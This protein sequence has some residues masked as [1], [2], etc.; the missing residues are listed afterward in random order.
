MFIYRN[1]LKNLLR[2]KGRN[3]LVSL[4]LLIVM[5]AA[6][7]S[8]AV[9]SASE[10]MIAD[11]QDS[12]GV[13]THLI[14]DWEYANEN[15][16]VVETVH[17]D[18]SVSI[19]SS[20]DTPEIP[21]EQFMAFAESDYV[22]STLF[23]A[24][25]L[26]TSDDIEPIPLDESLRR[27]EGMT[28][29]EL[30]EMFSKET[31]E[32]IYEFVGGAE[33]LERIISSRRDIVGSIWGYSDVS[34]MRDFLEGQRVIADGR[35]I[36]NPGEVIIGEKLAEL[37][38]LGV[39]DVFTVTGPGLNDTAVIP[40]TVVGIF[41]DYQANLNTA[42][43]WFGVEASDII[44]S[45]D[46]L[47]HSGFSD[48]FPIMEDIKFFLNDVYAVEPFAEELRYKGLSNFHT[49][50]SDVEGYEKIVEPVGNMSS[51]ATA[52]GVIVILTGAVILVFLSVINIRERK[53]EVGVLRAIGMKKH[54]LA[55]GLIC[56]SLSLVLLC[57]ALGLTAGGVLSDPVSQMLLKASEIVHEGVSFNPATL[58]LLLLIAL[59]LGV[60]SSLIGVLYITKYEPIKI[61]SEQN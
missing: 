14:M 4:I 7:V 34:I 56:E 52:F 37:N 2:N 39:G 55:G 3:I 43:V 26:Y 5:A 11:F 28:L 51:V 29:E 13:E 18:G 20:V 53:Y 8:L 49:L 41:T 54:Q 48:I 19:S 42:N 57:T 22:Q 21:I 38:G 12:F 59:S 24:A 23:S 15:A 10:A 60:M 17:D 36:E 16:A 1:A 46:T 33:G 45:F 44:V 35:L 27:L 9:R 25:G 32:D 61:L 6:T 50:Y 31:Q 30:L 40:L 58:P 47:Y